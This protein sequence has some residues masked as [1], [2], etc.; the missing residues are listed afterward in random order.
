MPAANRLPER[1]LERRL[2]ICAFLL[3]TRTTSPVAGRAQPYAS[4]SA[5]LAILRQPQ[6]VFQRHLGAPP[7]QTA[8]TVLTRVMMASVCRLLSPRV[9]AKM[10]EATART[11]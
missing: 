10:Q 4:L 2:A 11:Q 1:A 6:F 7:Q 9:V 8:R 3:V 5:L